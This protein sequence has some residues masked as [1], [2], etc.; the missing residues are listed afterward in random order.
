MSR[1]IFLLWFLRASNFSRSFS[2]FF[3][4]QKER[5]RTRIRINLWVRHI[6]MKS[7]TGDKLQPQSLYI[8]CAQKW[9]GEHS[10]HPVRRILIHCVI[11][12]SVLSCLD[13]LPTLKCSMNG[14]ANPVGYGLHQGSIP[15]VFD[16]RTIP[17]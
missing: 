6:W 4:F 2:A 16:V 10:F 7:Y 12:G 1:L 3:R 8:F 5:P 14:D 17:L 15:H 11:Y 9:Q 13:R